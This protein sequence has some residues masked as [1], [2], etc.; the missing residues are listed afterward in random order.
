MI[1]AILTF[2]RSDDGEVLNRQK[3][4]I[5]THSQKH[6]LPH[7]KGLPTCVYAVKHERDAAV[8]MNELVVNTQ[9]LYFWQDDEEKEVNYAALHFSSRKVKRGKMKKESPQECVYSVVRA[10]HHNRSQPSL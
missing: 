10:D 4:V 1:S 5:F 3:V 9:I 2:K 6:Q 7:L 8:C